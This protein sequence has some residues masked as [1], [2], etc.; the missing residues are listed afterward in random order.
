[1]FAL[2]VLCILYIPDLTPGGDTMVA[3]ENVHTIA[4]DL[5]SD[6]NGTIRMRIIVRACN[7][8]CNDCTL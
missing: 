2:G 3:R 4:N 1:M 8:I 5:C 6:V 7:T